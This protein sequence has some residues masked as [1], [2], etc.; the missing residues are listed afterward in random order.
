MNL[1]GEDVASSVRDWLKE[2]IKKGPGSKNDLGKFYFSVSIGTLALFAT[3]LKFAVV[4]PSLDAGT[5]SCFLILLLSSGVALYMAIPSILRLNADTE[6]YSAYNKM[7]DSIVVQ[8]GIW[9]AFWITG[10]VVGTI[11]LFS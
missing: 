5:C 1:K 9:F 4:S 11:K 2:E 6:L 3:L 10:F 7:I 8:T